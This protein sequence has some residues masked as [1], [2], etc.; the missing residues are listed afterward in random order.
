MFCMEA[1]V[2]GELEKK[3]NGT[4]DSCCAVYW[5]LKVLFINFYAIIRKRDPRKQHDGKVSLLPVT[6]SVW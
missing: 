2:A 1:K 6:A 5:C 3:I 4:K